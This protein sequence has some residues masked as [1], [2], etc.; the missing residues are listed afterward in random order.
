MLRHVV[1]EG[2][3]TV[4][5]PF[6]VGLR[7]PRRLKAPGF[8]DAFIGFTRHDPPPPHPTF[9]PDPDEVYSD[10]KLQGLRKRRGRGEVPLARPDRPRRGSA[11]IF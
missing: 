3:Q 6:R 2:F 10:W 5:Q 7:K 11:L 8:L 9:A 4:S 1:S